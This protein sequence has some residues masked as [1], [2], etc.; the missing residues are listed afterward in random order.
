VVGYIEEDAEDEYEIPK[1]TMKPVFV[2]IFNQRSVDYNNKFAPIRSGDD[3]GGELAE[4][5]QTMGPQN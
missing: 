4:E 2:N 1:K 3:R 5:R